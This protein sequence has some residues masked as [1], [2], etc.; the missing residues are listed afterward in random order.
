MKPGRYIIVDK[1]DF[2]T[3]FWVHT[4]YNMIDILEILTE[5]N[6]ILYRYVGDKILRHRDS[7]QFMQLKLTPHSPLMEELI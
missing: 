7:K 4:Y 3:P 5:T 2:E 1:D 6:E